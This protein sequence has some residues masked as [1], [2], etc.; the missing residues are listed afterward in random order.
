MKDNHPL[1]PLKLV[2]QDF[3]CR[4]QGNYL[5]QIDI[6]IYV[7]DITNKTIML[8]CTEVLSVSVVF[9]TKLVGPKLH[10]VALPVHPMEEKYQ[11]LVHPNTILIMNQ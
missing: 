6:F 8:L 5:H 4:Y 10:L 1:A 11:S 2:R 7:M 3:N 9:T